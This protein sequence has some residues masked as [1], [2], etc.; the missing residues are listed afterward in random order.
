M[1]FNPD[2]YLKQSGGFDP[3]DYLRQGA[4]LPIIPPN[5]PPNRPLQVEP[6]NFLERQ[7]AKLPDLISPKTENQIRGAVMGAADPSVGAAQ[8]IANAVG[9]GQGVNQAIQQKEQEY[10][11]G[12]KGVGR[13]GL[14]LPRLAGNIVISSLLRAPNLGAASQGAILG[15]LSPVTQGDFLE[16]KVM[17][18]GLGAVGGKS[19]ELVAKGVSRVLSPVNAAIV[20]KLREQGIN[21]TIGQSLGGAFNTAEEKLTSIPLMGDAIRSA[22]EGARDQFNRATINKALAP[23]GAKT[24]NI[25]QEGIRETG[26]KL[27]NAFDKALTQVKGIQLDKTFN[28]DLGNLRQMATGL[29]PN[30]QSKFEKLIADKVLG[31]ASPNGGMIGENFQKAYSD[32]GEEAGR[33]S[34]MQ[35]FGARDYANA[36]K[37]L[38]TILQEA[39]E[40]TSD[41]GAQSALKAAREGWANLV[42]VERAGTA[43]KGTEGVFTPGQ[44][45]SAIR[46]SDTSVRDRAT[47]RGTA[48]MQDWATQGQ[49]VLGNKYPDSGTAGRVGLGLGALATGAINPVIPAALA[50]GAGMYMP[51]IQRGL[52]SAAMD[53]PESAKIL[54][55]LLRKNPQLLAPA[56]AV[57]AQGINQ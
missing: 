8:L 41:P 30:F 4:P 40:R 49:K 22:R 28:Q 47:A 7:L 46:Q 34:G 26:D 38:Q 12:R 55:D 27:S 43:A 21:P 23:I 16:Q 10:Q 45:L 53:R 17:Q 37:Q 25:G 2:A 1:P 52:V 15:G 51:P 29:D 14:D 19:G 13:E 31:K 48:L 9:Q 44:L 50:G 20:N 36:V 18:T 56:G 57:A 11:E 54:A 5:N 24:E 6:P 35:N 42:R 32:L 39:A 3:D 33:F